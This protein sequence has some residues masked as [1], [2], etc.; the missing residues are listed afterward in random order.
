MHKG[1]AEKIEDLIDDK[2]E[3]LSEACGDEDETWRA[4]GVRGPSKINTLDYVERGPHYEMGDDVQ[5]PTSPDE[6][7]DA[8]PFPPPIP[9]MPHD[10]EEQLDILRRLVQALGQTA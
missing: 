9:R 5:P 3:D 8:D 7:L 10:D 1:Q 6:T 4:S 2:E